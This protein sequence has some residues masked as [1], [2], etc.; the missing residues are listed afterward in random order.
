MTTVLVERQCGCFRNSD[1]EAETQFETV[2][3]ALQKAQDMCTIM[4]EDF[5]H[6]HRFRTEYVEGQVI[7]KME[8][9]G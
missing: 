3:E 1:F 9:N 5:C 6:K 4:N 2:D 7:I 8:M